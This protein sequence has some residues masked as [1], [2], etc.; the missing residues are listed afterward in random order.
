MGLKKEHVVMVD[1]R[2]ATPG[3]P[4][5]SSGPSP[6][7]VAYCWSPMEKLIFHLSPVSRRKSLRTNAGGFQNNRRTMSEPNKNRL[8]NGG[9]KNN[10]GFLKNA[11]LSHDVRT[12]AVVAVQEVRRR[13][14]RAILD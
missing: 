10:N 8:I 12:V 7:S 3:A 9:A 2:N 5:P 11:S 1:Q 6:L 13:R 14:S 4:P